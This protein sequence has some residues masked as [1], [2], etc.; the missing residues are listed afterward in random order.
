MY[1][2]QEVVVKLLITGFDPFN[3]EDINPSWEAVR[4]L[5]D[6]IGDMDLIKKQIPTIFGFSYRVLKELIIEH[7]PDAVLCVGQAGGRDAV[8]IERIAINLD[9][10]RIPDNNGNKPLDE[11][12]FIDGENAYFSNLPVKAMARE[13]SSCGISSQISNSAGT[14]VCNHIMYSLLYYINRERLPIKGGFVHVPYI[15]SQIPENV[16]IPSMELNTIVRALT[17]AVYAIGVYKE[18][19]R[20]GYGLEF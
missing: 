8:S 12:I 18:D 13:I 2:Y 19:I 7:S 10:A 11:K 15:P 20:M 6:R 5:Q 9:D 14:F 4:L 16:D 3:G 1:N 17:A